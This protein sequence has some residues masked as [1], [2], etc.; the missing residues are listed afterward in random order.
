MLAFKICLFYIS[1]VKM[2]KV[3]IFDW[4]GTLVDSTELKYQAWFDLFP[5]TDSRIRHAAIKILP[6]LRG[7]PR[8][9]I[10][11]RI[12]LE[13]KTVGIS[14]FD[15]VSIYQKKYGQIVCNQIF[16]KGLDPL[17]VKTLNNLSRRFGLFVNSTTPETELRFAVKG[18]LGPE[19]F[20]GIYGRKNSEKN[21][22]QEKLKTKNIIK[23]LGKSGAKSFEAVAI[24]DSNA[25]CASAVKC[26]V[27]FIGIR[28]DSNKFLWKRKEK[29]P[30]LENFNDVENVIAG[31]SP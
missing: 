27:N 14:M 16:K 25:D 24:G 7:Y 26:A 19:L 22:S 6:D 3:I 23:I 28:N 12:F 15:F 30:V 21:L 29:F 17:V 9:E 20:A 11:E 18:L 31:L 4:D 1:I 13:A 2:I 10:L 8:A 5:E